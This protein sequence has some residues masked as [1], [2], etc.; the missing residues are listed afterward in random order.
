MKV[1]ALIALLAAVFVFWQEDWLA[2]AFTDANDTSEETASAPGS[3]TLAD[4]ITSH[5]NI[6]RQLRGVPALLPDP[7]LQSW[8]LNF[9]KSG[10][11]NSDA[12]VR[13]LG[14]DWPQYQNVK[15]VQTYSLLADEILGRIDEW[16]DGGL[17]ELTHYCAVIV[18]GTFHIGSRVTVL[19]GLRLPLLSPEALGDAKQDR[20]YAICPLCNQGQPCQIPRH[21]SAFKLQCESCGHIYGMLAADTGEH[22]HY[23]TEFLTGN[24]PPIQYPPGQSKLEELMT[25]WRAETGRCRYLSDGSYEDNENWQTSNET[26]ER[27]RGECEDLAILL[28]DWLL[29]RGFQARVV[30]GS[31][32]AAQ[33]AQDAYAWVVV[34]LDGKDYL[35]ESTEFP[36]NLQSPPLLSEAG[37]RYVPELSFDRQ[38][39]FVP[40]QP[41][42]ASNGDFWGNDTW[43]RVA[44]TRPSSKP[45]EQAAR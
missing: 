32:P 15:V 11:M 45:R 24:A 28:A 9:A 31:H 14:Q 1:V 17:P 5:M 42:A 29:T 18:P 4:R 2:T 3:F 40:K 12:I 33:D 20:F 8:L 21:A 36:L 25:I 41:G 35:L 44:T 37:S 10:A 7:E 6:K 30:I 23:V 19:A 27:R 38:A 13:T 34:R 22:F 16:R 39:I 26:Y 43:Q